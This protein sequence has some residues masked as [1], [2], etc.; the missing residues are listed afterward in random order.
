MFATLSARGKSGKRNCFNTAIVAPVTMTPR[1]ED[2][3]SD[4]NQV[5]NKAKEF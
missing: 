5:R 4:F 2:I 1:V 3:N